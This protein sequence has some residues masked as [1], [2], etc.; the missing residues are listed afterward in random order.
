MIDQTRLLAR[1]AEELVG[2]PF[3]MHGRDP[4]IGIDCVGLVICALRTIGI[5]GIDPEGYALR[6]LAVDR[7]IA[8]AAGLGLEEASGKAHA[9]DVLLFRLAAVQY[10]LGIVREDGALIHA[11]AG[12]GR[13]VVTP[14]PCG[15]PIERHWRLSH[16]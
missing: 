13:V 15:W 6:N 8:S 14:H 5:E 9:G 10:H 1:A 7:Q 4:Q 16:R 12:L 11:H 2:S 3:R